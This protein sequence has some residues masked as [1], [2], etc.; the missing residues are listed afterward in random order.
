LYVSRIYPSSYEF[1]VVT[2]EELTTK[3]SD[4][5]KI[6]A[7]SLSLDQELTGKIVRIDPYYLLVDVG[8]NRNGLIPLQKVADLYGRY[9]PNTVEGIQQIFKD[10][11]ISPSFRVVVTS[12]EQKRL[13]LDFAPDVKHSIREKQNLTIG[14]EVTGTVVNVTSFGV[15]LNIEATEQN[16]LLRIQS[17]A[18]LYQKF[19]P[20]IKGL[21]EVG[22]QLGSK[23]RVA[24]SGIDDDERYTLDYTDDAKREESGSSSEEAQWEEYAASSSSAPEESEEERQ[25]R[26]EDEM[27]AAYGG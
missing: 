15:F 6:P 18:E 17:V 24:I 9:V 25:R 21:M 27:W 10:E 13:C 5:E 12:N 19:I 8:A 1:E 23:H 26:E 14:K 22:F 3:S 7:S 16:G 20:E 11:L 4:K 2:N